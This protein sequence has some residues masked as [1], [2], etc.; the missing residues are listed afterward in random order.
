MIPV[1]STDP[2]AHSR[3]PPPSLGATVPYI[4]SKTQ[5]RKRGWEIYH[6]HLCSPHP[7]CIPQPGPG[8]CSPTSGERSQPVARVRV[9]TRQREQ[10]AWA[11]QV[12]HLAKVP[13]RADMPAMTGPT[14]QAVAV[15]LGSAVRLT[16]CEH[17]A[18]QQT[19]LQ[20]R[21]Q[22]NVDYQHA[23]LQKFMAQDG[24][25]AVR[26]IREF[27]ARNVAACKVVQGAEKVT[28]GARQ[29]LARDRSIAEEAVDYYDRLEEH[30]QAEARAQA[31]KARRLAAPA[32]PLKR[33]LDGQPL[34]KTPRTLRGTAFSWED[35]STLAGR[36][37][38]AEEYQN[39][40]AAG[41][42]E[43]RAR[44]L[45]EAAARKWARGE[46]PTPPC[47]Q[48]ESPGGTVLHWASPRFERQAAAPVQR[49]HG[50]PGAAPPGELGGPPKDPN[51]GEPLPCDCRSCSNPSDV[52]LL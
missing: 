24:P 25:E 42:S 6:S 15:A 49:R 43:G 51:S 52:P 36:D 8:Y 18:A 48:L 30:R 35:A 38:F 41:E 19:E 4:R 45:A 3:A 47:H 27:E 12:P 39:A 1:P 29:R 33:N 32:I 26:S 31:H 46:H 17:T 11:Q 5:H 16:A 37:A 22:G 10:Q 40:L 14:K 50:K 7:P 21:V 23:R 34:W 20:G 9:D 2:S 44:W 28:G 13:T